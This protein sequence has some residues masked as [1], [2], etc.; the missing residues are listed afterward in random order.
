MTELFL[1]VVNM[2]ISA[3]WLI[4][5]I[6][7]LRLVLRKAPKWVNVLLWGIVAVRLLCPFSIESALS[8]VP[9]AE[10]ISPEIMMNAEPSIHTG[11]PMINSVVN[12][13]ISQSFS[14]APGDSAN[15]LQIWI[16][17]LALIWL[18]GVSVLLAYT[19]IS[20]RRLRRNVDTAVFLRDNIFQSENVSSPFV[21]GIIK[22]KIY[23]P[24]RMDGQELE[25]VV[26]HEQAHIGRRDHWWK[27]LGFLLLTIHW[28]NPLMWLAYVFLCRDIELACDETVI[29]ELGA[30][31]RA[32][33][34]QALLTCSVSRRMVSACPLAFGEVG[35][36]ER[37]KSVLGYKKPAFWIVAASVVAC[38]VVAVCF[39]TNPRGIKIEDITHEKGYTITKQVKKGITLS[40]PKDLLPDTIYTKDGHTFEENEVVA[41]QTDTSVIYLERV[42]L[43]NE[44]DE[45]LYFIF[46]CSYDLP[47][48]GSVLLPYQIKGTRDHLLISPVVM[49][50]SRT[51]TDGTH[52]YEDAVRLRAT[53]PNRQFTFYVDTDACK[54]AEGTIRIQMICNELSYVKNGSDLYKNSDIDESLGMR[55][56]LD[57]VIWL[58][59]KKENLSWSDFDRFP[60]VET[61]SGLYIRIYE[62]DERFRLAIGG[63]GPNRKPM[64]IYLGVYGDDPNA[65]I[66][67][68]DGG[69][70]EFIE[71]H[72]NGVI[73]KDPL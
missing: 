14:P 65:R 20:Y 11:V 71:Q 34:S 42:M 26:A 16:P 1:N 12:P 38:A 72:R 53:G 8:L 15:P 18:A 66:D 68:R 41:Y 25:H 52:A 67:I 22:P 36:K 43:A 30:E 13:V 28:F 37:V 61:G 47:E 70:A 27:P 58:S 50:S 51:L 45:Y 23:L 63:A 64:Y 40:V 5:A 57:D 31:Q 6:L 17:A 69:V 29:Q 3:S 62:I 19:A 39:L 48:S 73:A 33:Y 60:Y 46:N 59:E 24:F 21:L 32:D 54:A 9:S 44:G 49:A 10:T 4:L 56:A 7:M 2:S 55:L 35:V